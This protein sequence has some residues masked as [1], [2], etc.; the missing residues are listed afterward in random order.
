M[1]TDL[2]YWAGLLCCCS[3][4]L[5]DV[6]PSRI[7]GDGREKRREREARWEGSPGERP[8]ER[9]RELGFLL[10]WLSNKCYGIK[11]IIFASAMQSENIK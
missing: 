9:V 11:S 2:G 1:L 7:Q 8:A 10:A 5:W 3:E 6:E 4:V